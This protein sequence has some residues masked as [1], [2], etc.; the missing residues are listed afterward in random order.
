VHTNVK[1]FLTQN[2]ASF[3]CYAVKGCLL[4][5]DWFIGQIFRLL[6]TP[7]QF[8]T[9][10]EGNPL[11][12]IWYG[13]TRMTGYSLVA[14]WSTKSFGHSTLTW[15]THRQPRRY[16]K[17]RAN[18]VCVRRRKSSLIFVAFRGPPDGAIGRSTFPVV[19][20]DYFAQCRRHTC[21]TH[22]QTD[23][24]H[25]YYSCPPFGRAG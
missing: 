5:N 7:L 22:R 18:A 25:R 6:L 19:T 12:H 10:S 23:N 8:D 20:A 9:P 14:W 24:A 21:A 16:S 11:V 17:F 1:I 4:V 3:P 2:A 15:Q 13:K